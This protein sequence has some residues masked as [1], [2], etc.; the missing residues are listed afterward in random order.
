M[1]VVTKARFGRRSRKN[2][3]RAVRGGVFA[4]QHRF[5]EPGSAL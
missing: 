5:V 2:R 4:A 1:D 3:C